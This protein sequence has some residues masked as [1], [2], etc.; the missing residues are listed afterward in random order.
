[1]MMD[2]KILFCIPVLFLLMTKA[3][4]ATQSL[5]A[6]RQTVE[7]Y[8]MAQA[9]ALY[10]GHDD[11]KI[12]LGYL[13]SALKLSSCHHP[14][15]I[16][17]HSVQI[18]HGRFSILIQCRQPKRWKIVLPIQ[19]QV[20]QDIAVAKQFLARGTIV[21]Q[22]DIGYVRHNITR[23]SQGYFDSPEDLIGKEVKRSIRQG[24][25]FK[26][27]MIKEP[28]L[29]KRG[30]TVN[31]ISTSNTLTVQASGVALQDGA[32][33]EFISVKNKSSKRTIEGQVTAVDTITVHL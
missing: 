32:K 26:P 12:Q 21:T 28:L 4:A 16:N 10:P 30:S 2:V 5:D 6:L 25:Y 22:A 14:I 3:H 15:E 24:T 33:G 7:T 17:Q 9:Q 27:N 11:V 19:V 18:N 20:F 23:L 31:I 13:D 1:M 8:A 29:V